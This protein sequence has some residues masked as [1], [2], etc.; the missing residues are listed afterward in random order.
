[1]TRG[2]ELGPDLSWLGFTSFGHFVYSNQPFVEVLLGRLLS[3]CPIV[4]HDDLQDAVAS[5]LGEVYMRQTQ[6]GKEMV[7]RFRDIQAKLDRI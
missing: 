1:M 7:S 3:F 2:P 6:E 5:Y 4:L